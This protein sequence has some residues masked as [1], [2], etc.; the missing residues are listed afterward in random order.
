MKKIVETEVGTG[1]FESIGEAQTS[2]KILRAL[3]VGTARVGK[4]Q[5]RTRRNSEADENVPIVASALSV[6]KTGEELRA[7][8]NG[9]A[10]S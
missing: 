6:F 2:G 7:A 8:V 3:G 4:R 9:G 1:M 5:S 10:A